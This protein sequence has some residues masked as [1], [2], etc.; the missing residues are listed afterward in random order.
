MPDGGTIMASRQR[1]D[2]YLWKGVVVA[3]SWPKKST[4]PRHGGEI[5]SSEEFKVA[6]V[7]TGAVGS[8]IREGLVAMHAGKGVTWVDHFRAMARGKPWIVLG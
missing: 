5:L 7:M 2:Y 3:R 4:Q 1:V 8:T 6:A